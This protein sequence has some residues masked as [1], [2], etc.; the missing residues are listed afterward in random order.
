MTDPH[1]ERATEMLQVA[2]RYIREH[3]DDKLIFYD[4]APCDGNC[5]ADD[6]ESAAAGL[7]VDDGFE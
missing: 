5:V 4:E 2:A 1:L 6:C 7:G 3:C